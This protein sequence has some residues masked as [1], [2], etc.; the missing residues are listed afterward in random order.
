MTPSTDLFQN[1]QEEIL[2]HA[3]DN[4]PA[5]PYYL[6]LMRSD[7]SFKDLDYRGTS[8]ASATDLQGHGKR[9][10][11]YSQAYK[12]TEHANSYYGDLTLK[13]QI[14]KGWSYVAAKGGYVNAPNWWWK[15]IGVPQGMSAGLILMR[16]EMS[17]TLRN[18]ILTKYF[19]TVWN[20][21]KYD[22]AN[23]TYQAPMAIIDGLLRG[24]SGRIRDVVSRVSGELLAYSGEGIQRDL[25]F[26]QHKVNGKY[27]FYS[28]SYGLVFARD[29]SRIMRWVADTP[30]A[31]GA[32]AI[33]Q[34]LRYTLD[35][36]A[37]LTRGDTMEIAAQGRGIT[38]P[39]QITNAPHVLRDAVVDML[40]LGR[41]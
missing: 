5:V 15:A 23:L 27:N 22:G 9:L 8:D 28:G 33:D 10:E 35:H 37:W 20:P 19:A 25:S 32:A 11:R 30:Y 7:G 29:T 17:S 4:L 26:W 12:W 36:M 34:Q 18:Q 16:D 1:I 6:G 13:A 41:R 40:I 3:P 38:R 21:S 14:L 24:N 31:F 39:G 2:E